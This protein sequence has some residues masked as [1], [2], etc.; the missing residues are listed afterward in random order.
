VVKSAQQFRIGFEPLSRH[1]FNL[2]RDPR[3]R[4]YKNVRRPIWP[5]DE[6]TELPEQVT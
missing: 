6:I 5:L 3:H 1:I 2:W 4:N